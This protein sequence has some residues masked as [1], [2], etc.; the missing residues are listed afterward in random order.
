MLVIPAGLAFAL[1]MARKPD[2]ERYQEHQGTKVKNRKLANKTRWIAPC[3]TLVRPEPNV[4]DP[5]KKVSISKVR[6]LE[7]RPRVSGSLNTTHAATTIGMVRPILAIAD[8]IVKFILVC[9][10]SALAARTA[11]Q[12]S[13]KSTI[14]AITMPARALGAFA[15]AMTEYIEGDRSFAEPTT[16]LKEMSNKNKLNTALFFDGGDACTDS[17]EADSVG[18]K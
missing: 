11:A 4:I 7:S 6:S 8:P 13:G 17:S 10:R 5:I 15:N 14:A 18:R 1:M 12:A 16:Q 9:N 2:L 3:I